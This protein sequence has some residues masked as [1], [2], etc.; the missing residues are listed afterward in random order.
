MLYCLIIA[1]I[2][3]IILWAKIYFMKKSAREISE[4]LEEIL[5]SDTN[6]L[7]CV[8]GSDRD[9]KALAKKINEELRILRKE[10][11]R[12]EQG[13]S[14]LNNA[15]TN[16]SH[17]LRTPLT[18][19][20]GY[21]DL[22]KDVEDPGKLK[23]YVG[24]VRERTGIMKQLTEELFRYS[25]IVSKEENEIQTEEVFVNQVLEESI[26]S[27]YP[28][29]TE[30]GIKPRIEITEKRIVRFVNKSELSRVFSNLL[31]NA[32]KYS[33]GDLDISLSD[34]GEI[35]FANTAREL[36]YVNTQQ[37]FDRFYT[38][39]NAQNSTGLGLSIART[40]VERMGG[41]IFADYSNYRLTIKIRL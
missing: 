27:F 20:C 16:I 1:L 8:S 29:L 14:E 26:G 34:E 7:I 3:L 23:R 18:A 4:Q 37:L 38:V 41:E 22:M 17:D 9:I 2:V 15:I 12:Y 39:K 35:V 24:I 31:S 28:A 25:L 33:D 21:L 36:S 19:I 10:R 32:I 5:K 13:N 11:L 40:L 30:R 6:N